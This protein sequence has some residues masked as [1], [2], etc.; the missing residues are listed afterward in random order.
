M[1]AA[2]D[3][4]QFER[5]LSS[6]SLLKSYVK[7]KVKEKR[8]PNK[9]TG[10]DPENPILPSRDLEGTALAIALSSKLSTEISLKKNRAER[11]RTVGK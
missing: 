2:L 10:P 11:S 8:K 6:S 5:L 1:L 7:S 4:A 9:V 3:E